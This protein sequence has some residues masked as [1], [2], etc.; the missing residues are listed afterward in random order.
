MTVSAANVGPEM[1]REL[2][3][4]DHVRRVDAHTLAERNASVRV[5]EKAGMEGSSHDFGKIVRLD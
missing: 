1:I 4:H 3:A 5:P 2:L